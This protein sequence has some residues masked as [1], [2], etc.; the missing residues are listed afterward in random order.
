MSGEKPNPKNYA[1]SLA[2][3]ILPVFI[4]SGLDYKTAFYDN[5]EP[6]PLSYK[7]QAK[8]G[9]KTIKLQ[10]A[11]T[12]I[13]FAKGLTNRKSI[14]SNEGI[15]YVDLPSTKQ[16]HNMRDMLFSSDLIFLSRGKV[17]ALFSNLPICKQSTPKCQSYKPSIDYD[18]VIELKGGAAEENGIFQG[19]VLKIAWLK[20]RANGST[21]L[22]Q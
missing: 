19:S 2:L 12:P 13:G 4:V 18:S 5:S 11:D 6:Q 1:L 7:G 16:S 22:I 21:L 15:L 3:F 20:T 14:G 17:V 9:V 8:I 10:V